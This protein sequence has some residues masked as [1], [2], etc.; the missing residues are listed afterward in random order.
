MVSAFV[1]IIGVPIQWAFIAS[2][3]SNQ[4]ESP[5]PF[6]IVT[7]KSS[8]RLTFVVITASTAAPTATH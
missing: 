4:L 6:E 3:G 7:F 8:S 5:F 2:S 1:L